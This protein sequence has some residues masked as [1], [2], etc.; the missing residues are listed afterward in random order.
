MWMKEEITASLSSGSIRLLFGVNDKF[1]SGLPFTL[2]VFFSQ[3][4]LLLFMF[5]LEKVPNAEDRLL[6]LSSF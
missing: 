1:Y 5:I 6:Y 3:D 2:H 4:F